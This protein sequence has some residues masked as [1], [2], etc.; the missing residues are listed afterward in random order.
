MWYIL[1]FLHYLPLSTTRLNE[2]RE[3]FPAVTLTK[4]WKCLPIRKEAFMPERGARP[5]AKKVMVTVTDGESHVS[6]NQKQV[7]EDCEKDGIER[8]GIAVGTHY[9]CVFFTDCVSVWAGAFHG[10]RGKS[11][12]CH[13][14]FW[15]ILFVIR[16]KGRLS[17]EIIEIIVVTVVNFAADVEM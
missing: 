5:G 6:H 16:E 4:F 17:M 7:I 12:V 15:K 13:E 3:M 14:C 8:F 11:C 9:L 2:V 10:L 1:V